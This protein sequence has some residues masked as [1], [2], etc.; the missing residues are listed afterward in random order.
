MGITHSLGIETSLLAD[1]IQEIKDREILGVFGCPVFGFKQDNINFMNE[2]PFIEQVWFWE[3]E[4]KNIDG[5]Y[6]L[7]NLSYFGIHEKRPAID[8]SKF[9][10]LKKAVWQ[11]V[12]KDRGMGDLN[13]LQGLDLWRFKPKDKTYSSIE[14]PKSLKQ[15]DLNWCNPTSLKGMPT[16]SN[17]EAL[18]IHYCRNLETIDSIFEFAPNLKKLVI[19]RCANLKDFKVVLDHDWEH[20][21]I[22]IK[23]KTVANKSSKKDAQNARASS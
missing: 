6:S 3:I 4:L 17:L 12:R 21:H 5:L 20:M 15:L 23:G 13:F 11:P 22:D 19:T 10:K 8:F 1:C 7:N 9:A 16:L 2:I 14:L 18:Q